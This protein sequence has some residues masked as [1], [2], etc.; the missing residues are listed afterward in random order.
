MGLYVFDP[1]QTY[2]MR[3]VPDAQIGVTVNTRSVATRVVAG[4]QEHRSQHHV[5]SDD[6]TDTEQWE[7]R[8]GREWYVI[9][10]PQGAQGAPMLGDVFDGL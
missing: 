5:M 4:L 7:R 10:W 6:P 1:T 9:A 8:V 2:H 3:G